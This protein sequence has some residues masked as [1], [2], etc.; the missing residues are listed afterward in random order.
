MVTSCRRQA[1]TLVELLVVITI[2][3]ILI[4]L[5][6]P[7][8]QAAREAARRGQCI[9]NEKQLAL[10]LQNYQE[11][12]GRFPPGGAND[13]RPFGTTGG[14]AYGSAWYAYILPYVEQGAIF[15]RLVFNGNSGWG[16]ANNAQAITN[17]IIAAFACPS[18]PLPATC[19]STMS[20]NYGPVQSTSYVG[21]SGPVDLFPY[22]GGTQMIPGFNETRCNNGGAGAGC[23]TG[24]RVCAGGVLF[25]NSQIKM[26]EITDGSSNVAVIG[27]QAD[28]ITTQD[29]TKQPWGTGHIHG[30]LIGASSNNSPPN[31]N[32]GGDAR[33]FSLTTVR[34]RINQ[35]TGW[36]NTPGDCGNLGVCDNVGSNIPLLSAHPGGVNLALCDGSVR[37][38]IDN[39]PMDVLARL[40]TRDDGFPVGDY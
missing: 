28:W 33:T 27:E 39:I 6:L 22:P 29:G 30:M 13:Q 40:C 3:G 4:A 26:S 25:P 24:G 34:W 17:V 21:I 23:C 15:D 19:W 14:V 10:S 38:V 9:N 31:Y 12:Y 35:K 1:F 11:R 8:V 7:A 32:V 5:L 37:F 36:P 2:I 16:S 20:N 18:S